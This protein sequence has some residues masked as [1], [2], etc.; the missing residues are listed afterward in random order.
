MSPPR[1]PRVLF[2]MSGMPVGG[3]ERHTLALRSGLD[4][5]GFPTDIL[6]YGWR[7]SEVIVND[8][9]AAGAIQLG[10]RGMS[11]LPGWRRAWA[12]LRR[13]RP[14]V[15]VAV[16]QA[17]LVIA[18]V[19][20]LLGATR[21]RIGCV[22]HT[23]IL[24]PSE[25]REQALFLRACRRADALVYVSHRQAEYW[26]ARGLRARRELTIQN[27]VD[28]ARFTPDPG[29]RVAM[30][31]RLGVAP[32]EVLVGILAS[33][34]APKN[35]RQLV[36]AVARLIGEGRPVR[37]LIV[38]DGP[39]RRDLDAQVAALGIGAR[40]T[41]VDAQVDVRPWL[42]ACDV[43]VICSV[44]VETFSLAALEFLACGV[45]MVMSDIGGASE[46]VEDGRNGLLIPAGSVDALAEALRR[47]SD[48]PT[49]KHWAARA[50]ASVE[51][52]ALDRMVDRYADLV[53]TLAAPSP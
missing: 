49:R 8:P 22:F 6:V 53:A 34:S 47:M 1:S 9:A 42:H 45:P 23:T 41:F 2:L 21:A 10:A 31:E 16:N 28:L 46:I 14:D 33:L 24:R 26:A 17:P 25:R 38:G 27:G 39:L 30:R 36:E 52:L 29:G 3:A 50:R 11:S 13:I 7:R 44:A 5:R 12:V 51:H 35:H 4:R 37:L 19:L 20:R 15:I 40:V 48:A 32:D 18:V 43:G